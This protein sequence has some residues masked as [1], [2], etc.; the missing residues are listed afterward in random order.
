M[1]GIPSVNVQVLQNSLGVLPASD[2]SLYAVVGPT[3]RGPVNAPATYGRATD[4]QAD[5]GTGPAV[6]AACTI[7]STTGNAVCI[8]RTA[9]TSAGNFTT[10]NVSGKT[11]TSTI[12][13]DTGLADDDYDVVFTVTNGGTVGTTG[14]TFTTSLDGSVN[15]SAVQS[16]GTAN[17]YALPGAGGATIKFGTGTLVTGDVVT[18]S[19]TPSNFAPADLTN[20]LKALSNSI[21]SWGTALIVGP[22]SPAAFDAT[23]LVFAG[24]EEENDPHTWIANTRLPN[25]GETEAAYFTSVSGQFANKATKFGALCYGGSRQTSINTGLSQVRPASWTFAA[26]QSTLQIEQDAADLAYGSLPG[27]LTDNNGNADPRCHDERVFPGADAARFTTLRTIR[28]RQGVYLTRPR[29]FSSDS[30]DFQLFPHALVMQTM[31]RVLYNYLLT[32]LNR[33]IRVS[34]QT[35]FIL[36]TDARIIEDGANS[37]LSSAL[38]TRPSASDVLFVLGRRDNLLSGAA[39]TCT[40]TCTPLAYVSTIDLV[41]GFKNPALTFVAV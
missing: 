6:E 30:S 2:G 15:T 26:R 14:I 21:V 27:S 11:G 18:F 20:A 40:A 13:L 12:T 24:L 7:V 22:F 1:S 9:A 17:T 23:E 25:I 19:T 32:W 4:I 34:K 29:I 8:V 35:G 39:M 3:S 41:L 31:H 10:I 5:F 38:L 37:E 36:E 16:L 33:P 28:G